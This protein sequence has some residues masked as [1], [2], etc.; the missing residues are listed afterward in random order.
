MRKFGKILKNQG[1]KII[2][3]V[4]AEY[5]PDLNAHWPQIGGDPV[6]IRRISGGY[7]PEGFDF[8]AQGTPAPGVP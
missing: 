4:S 7:P 6:D 3:W 2:R 5:P 1:R 8:P